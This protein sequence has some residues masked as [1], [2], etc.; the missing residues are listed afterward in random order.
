MEEKIEHSST[1][2]PDGRIVN[3]LKIYRGHTGI[4]N[5]ALTGVRN[6]NW[7]RVYVPAG[8]RLISAS[9]FSQ[10]DDEYFEEPDPSWLDSDFLA[11]ERLSLTDQASGAKIYTEHGKTVFAGWVMTDPG[12]TAEITFVYELPF[13]FFR[14]V[15]R[16]GFLDK[17]NSLLNPEFKELYPYSLLV[18]KQPG[19]KPS[20]FSS[21]LKAPSGLSARWQHPES[22]KWQSGW[23]YIGEIGADKYISVLLNK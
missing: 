20:Q 6:V 2:S 15:A 23:S 13:N 19:A 12:Q 11:E 7:L 21:V 22:L 1:V 8:S 9:G 17:L 5:E 10:P 14:P 18:Q 3:T 4:K 16:D